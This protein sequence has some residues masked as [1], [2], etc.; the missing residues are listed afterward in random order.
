MGALAAM[1]G[2]RQI[3]RYIREVTEQPSEQRS[4]VDGLRA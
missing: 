3:G 2:L 1:P 4:S